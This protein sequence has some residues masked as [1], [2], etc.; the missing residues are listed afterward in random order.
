MKDIE[1]KTMRRGSS[2]FEE[3]SLEI[4]GYKATSTKAVNKLSKSPLPKVDNAPRKA[5]PRKQLSTKAEN[6]PSKSRQPEL[7]TISQ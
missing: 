2:N 5:F 3:R 1:V 6:Q 4:S 7:E